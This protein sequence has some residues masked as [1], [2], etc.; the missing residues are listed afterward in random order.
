MLFGY[1]NP[2]FTWPGNDPHAIFERTRAA[3]LKAEASGFVSFWLMDHLI[4]LPMVGAVDEP[5]L[6]GWTTLAALAAVTSRI[7]LGTMVSSVGYR[8]P[9]LL[10][11][12]VA[13]VDIISGGRAILGIGAGWFQTEYRQ[14]GYEFPEQPA[15]RI[16]QLD[17][18]I[19]VIKAMW[20]QPRAT[21]AGKYFQVKD[22]I[23]EPKPVQK[24]HPPILVGGGGEQLT[25]K[26]AAKQANMVNWFGPPE[27]VKHKLE[28]L[29]RHCD[30]VGRDLH[31]IHIT[32]LDTV[33]IGRQEKDVQ[34]K[35]IKLHL[36]DRPFLAGAVQ[37]VIDQI[38]AFQAVG[39]QEIIL[40]IPRNDPETLDLLGSEVIPAF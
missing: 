10:A 18:G 25:L 22:A 34:Q 5:F 21:F 28:V 14:Y 16:R 7:R 40:N 12:M 24:P 31:E 8:N 2:S 37:Q 32:K 38:A 23:L 17:E 27:V 30:T 4:Q 35:C 6:E 29:A 36:G 3:A 11:K 9:A 15:V 13:G 1:Q 33:L 20:T 26:V 19:Q 39:V